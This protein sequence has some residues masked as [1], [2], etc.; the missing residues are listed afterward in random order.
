MSEERK[1]LVKKHEKILAD[2]TKDIKKKK[3]AYKEAAENKFAEAEASYESELAEFDV[4]HGGSAAA[5]ASLKKPTQKVVEEV[6]VKKKKVKFDFDPADLNGMSKV[7]S[8]THNSQ[9]H[10]HH[11]SN[12]T[13]TTIADDENNSV[14][15]CAHAR[16]GLFECVCVC[17][18][19]LCM[20]VCANACVGVRVV[21]CV[22]VCVCAC[23][24]V[25]LRAAV[26][27]GR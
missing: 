4:T 10:T 26:Q 6:E 3:G 5:T 21:W 22:R 9:Q 14:C 13:S 2:L 16:R 12:S 17:S 27:G 20:C 1:A 19:C 18:W 25:C 23:V 15:M 8:A 24:C 11:S 7:H